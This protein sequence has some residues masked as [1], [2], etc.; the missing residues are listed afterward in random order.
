MSWLSASKIGLQ[1]CVI[2]PL[3]LV[4]AVVIAVVAIV[5]VVG[6]G[7]LS[8][9]PRSSMLHSQLVPCECSVVGADLLCSFLLASTLYQ[10]LALPFSFAS[11]TFF[12]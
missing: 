10:E 1:G 6:C 5:L 8:V 7:L 9:C 11:N 3:G 4:V 2:G 12:F